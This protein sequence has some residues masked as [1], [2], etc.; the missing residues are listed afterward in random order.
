MDSELTFEQRR[1]IQNEQQFHDALAAVD[2]L[3]HLHGDDE[4]VALKAAQAEDA[5]RAAMIGSD[6]GFWRE[7]VKVL[8]TSMDNPWPFEVPRAA[9]R[10]RA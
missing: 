6:G 8:Q 2:F 1:A 7:V 10:D 4:T 9:L 5:R 3:L